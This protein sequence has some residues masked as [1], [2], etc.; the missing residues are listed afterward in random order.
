M[1]Y[2]YKHIDPMAETANAID[3]EVLVR[4]FTYTGTVFHLIEAN[5]R[6]D[7]EWV[8]R[9]EVEQAAAVAALAAIG[10]TPDEPSRTQKDACESGVLEAIEREH[11][12]STDP[13]ERVRLE[14]CL[15]DY[16]GVR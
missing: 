12:F 3:Q 16:S 2:Q 13:E 9:L 8:A 10:R 7:A 1:A 4:N 6:Q 11:L 5:L 15:L 14:T